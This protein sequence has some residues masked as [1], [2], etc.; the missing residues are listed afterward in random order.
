MN[1][2][3]ELKIIR[4][5]FFGISILIILTSFLNSVSLKAGYET[6]YAGE[7]LSLELDLEYNGW[8]LI[9]GKDVPEL[10][11]ENNVN[12]EYVVVLETSIMIIIAYFLPFVA[13]VAML[14]LKKDRNVTGF[15]MCAA[16]LISAVLLFLTTRVCNM[17][18]AEY[19]GYIPI[20]DDS[21]SLQSMG[22]RTLIGPYI[23]AFLGCI[24]C[25]FSFSYA[26]KKENE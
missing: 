5:V 18:I 20:N 26:M 21:V 3:K 16:F 6:E 24:S 17:N 8:D 4:Y 13:A 23:G 7:T 1:K 14:L 25:V 15:I 9:L 11:L 19:N 10:H 12:S 2:N 22:F